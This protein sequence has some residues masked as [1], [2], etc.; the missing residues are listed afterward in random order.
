MT[1]QT[2]N[3]RKLRKLRNKEKKAAARVV[4]L[5]SPRT[6]AAAAACCICRQNNAAPTTTTFKDELGDAASTGCGRC[7]ARLLSSPAAAPLVGYAGVLAAMNG[8]CESLAQLMPRICCAEFLRDHSFLVSDMAVFAAS[9][10]HLAALAQIADAADEWNC[11]APQQPRAGW[12]DN[13]QMCTALA[14]NGLIDCLRF[15]LGRG[16]AWPDRAEFA[17]RTDVYCYYSPQAECVRIAAST[18]QLVYL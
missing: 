4:T 1:V 12:K 8:Q 18:H 5:T 16:H 17:E 10:G 13:A 9:C 3:M 11:A 6:A 14:S 2:R 15:V 7:L